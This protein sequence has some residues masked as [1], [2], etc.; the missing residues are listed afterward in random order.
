MLS[1]WKVVTFTL[2]I[3]DWISACIHSFNELCRNM[4]VKAEL[5]VTWFCNRCAA[6]FFHLAAV[7]VEVYVFNRIIL[8]GI[9]ASVDVE[10][11]RTVFT[12]ERIENINLWQRS[13][14]VEFDVAAYTGN[15]SGSISTS[16][17]D[18]VEAVV[19]FCH[20]DYLSDDLIRHKLSLGKAVWNCFSFETADCKEEVCKLDVVCCLSWKEDSSW[21]LRVIKR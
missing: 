9:C 15:V 14:L 4:V 18:V 16:K 19:E 10:L 20:I 13:C 5:I 11:S 3:A 17:L 1:F 6:K 21:D 7:D 8:F 2:C 12:V